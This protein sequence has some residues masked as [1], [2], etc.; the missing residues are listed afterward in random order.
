[1]VK[2]E[3]I[4]GR[5]PFSDAVKVGHSVFISGQIPKDPI[6]GGW[7]DNIR[8]QT[9]QCLENI[10]NILQKAGGNVSDI[11]KITIFL[12]NIENYG[13]MNEAFIDF[14]KKNKI[15]EDFPAR[16]A[17]QAGPLFYREWLIEIE[18]VAIIQEI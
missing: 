3:V 2:K 7:A 5:A 13:G 4:K 14:F 16:T 9:T 17:I 12:T 6:K 1:M 15:E 8:D 18:A 11:V 10:K